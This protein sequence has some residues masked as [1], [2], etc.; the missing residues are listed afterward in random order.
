[1]WVG[2]WRCVLSVKGSVEAL[3]RRVSRVLWEIW[4]VLWEVYVSFMRFVE[5][6]AVLEEI[7]CSSCGRVCLVYA[8]YD[9]FRE[10]LVGRGARVVV[11]EADDRGEDYPWEFCVLLFR[12]RRVELFWKFKVVESVE[13]Y[14]RLGDGG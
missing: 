4:C 13:V 2:L 10:F 6:R 3:W 12:G 5:A 9:Y 7:L 1:M 11:V 14:W 8:G